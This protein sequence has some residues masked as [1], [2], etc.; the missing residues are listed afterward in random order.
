[1]DADFSHDPS[2]I[3][4]VIK[5]KERIILLLVR[6]SVRVEKVIIKEQK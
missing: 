2:Y 3:P 5:L 1:M 6:S 4:D